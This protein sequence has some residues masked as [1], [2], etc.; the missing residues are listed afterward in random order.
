MG[1]ILMLNDL[2]E[3]FRVVLSKFG[4]GRHSLDLF[5]GSTR[6]YVGL[7]ISDHITNIIGSGSWGEG[8]RLGLRFANCILDGLFIHTTN[9]HSYLLKKIRMNI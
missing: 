2:L 4:K 9:I 5:H 8:K 1:E 6:I 7:Q 3:E